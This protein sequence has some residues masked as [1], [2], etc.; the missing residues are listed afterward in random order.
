M[1]KKGVIQM[2]CGML[3]GLGIDF[4]LW[5]VGWHLRIGELTLYEAGG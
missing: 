1:S 2:A 5:Y 4:S 3:G